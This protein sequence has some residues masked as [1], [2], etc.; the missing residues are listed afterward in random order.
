MTLEFKFLII[1]FLTMVGLKL[2]F[3]KLGRDNIWELPNIVDV[4]KILGWLWIFEL[5]IVLPIKLESPCKFLD[6]NYFFF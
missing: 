1:I 2:R 5:G 3:W 4:P 6:S